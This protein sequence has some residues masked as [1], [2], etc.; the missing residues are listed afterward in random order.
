M[1]YF[2]VHLELN[3]NI[4]YMLLLYFAF[5]YLNGITL[6][7]MN[8]ISHNGGGESQAR[9]IRQLIDEVHYRSTSNKHSETVFI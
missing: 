8:S 3:E 7:K 1:G 9:D 2:K 4:K 5:G 6:N